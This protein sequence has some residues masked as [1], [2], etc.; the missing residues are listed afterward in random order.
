MIGQITSASM[1]EVQSA[2]SNSKTAFSEWS[3]RSP[4]ER[5]SVLHAAGRLLRE[6]IADVSQIESI[7]TGT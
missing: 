6:N 3:A 4:A 5:S 1:D 7:D 2:I